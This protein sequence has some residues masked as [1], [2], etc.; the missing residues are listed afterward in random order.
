MN[1]VDLLDIIKQATLAVEHD[2]EELVYIPNNPESFVLFAVASYI[3]Q[4]PPAGKNP[5]LFA[6]GLPSQE[7]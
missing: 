3:Y 1:K 5:I 4:N 2:L 6:G 7:H